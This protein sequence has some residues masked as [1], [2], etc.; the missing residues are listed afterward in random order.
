MIP[1]SSK[2]FKRS[3]FASRLRIKA[4]SVWPLAPELEGEGVVG[5][6]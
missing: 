6:V 5:G 3:D 1:I 2:K 4:R